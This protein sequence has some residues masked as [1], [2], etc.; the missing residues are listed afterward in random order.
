MGG[1]DHEGNATCEKRETADAGVAQS[2]RC[3]WFRI[4]VV[5]LWMVPAL[6][7]CI[8]WQLAGT[9]RIAIGNGNDSELVQGF[10]PPEQNETTHYRWSKPEA[11]ITLPAHHLPGVL[12]L[13]GAVAPDGTRVTL[14]LGEK[15]RVEIPS[16]GNLALRRYLLLWPAET[17]AQGEVQLGMSAR[18][19]EQTAE[20]RPIGMLLTEVQI[21]AVAGALR[22]PPG[23]PLL[24]LGLFAPL[25]GLCLRLG[26]CCWHF[27][28]G[29]SAAA[30]SLLAGVWV[31]QPLLVRPFL[32]DGAALLAAG[33]LWRWWL[34]MQAV[35]LAALPLTLFLLRHLP[36]RGY[37]FGKTMGLLLVGYGSWLLAMLRLVPFG[38]TSGLLLLLLLAGAGLWSLRHERWST[39]AQG[40]RRRWRALLACEL[41]FTAAL[42][43]GVWLRWHG[44]MGPAIAGTE[45]PMELVLLSGVLRSPTF[46]PADP[47]FAGYSFNYYYMGY[48]LIALLQLLS[49]VNLG[50]AFNLGMATIFALTALSVAGLVVAMIEVTL[51]SEGTRSRQPF[52]PRQPSQPSRLSI[53]GAALLGLLLVLGAGNQMGT[54]QVLVGSPAV[55]TLDGGQIIAAVGQRL[56]GA[57][58]IRLDPPATALA[59]PGAATVITPA[60]TFTFDWWMP[61]RAVWDAVPLDDGTIGTIEKIERR[62]LITEFPFFSFYL[63]DLHPHVLALPVATLALGVTLALLVRPAAPDFLRGTGWLELGLTGVVPGMLYTINAWYAPTFL[64]V[65]AGGLVLLYR[66]LAGTGSIGSIG[67]IDWWGCLRN[68]G[69]VL[70]AMLLLIAPFLLTFQPPGGEQP[71][72]APWSAIPIVRGLAQTLAPAA[73]HTQLHGFLIVFGLF[74]LV[75]LAYG[76]TVTKQHCWRWG[77]P[78][79]VLLIGLP[80]DFPLLALLPTAGLLAWQAWA[81][82]EH[83]ARAL[84]LWGSAVGALVVFGVDIIYIR[85]YLEGEISRLNTLFKFY[86]Q[87]WLIWGVLAAYAAWALWR[88]RRGWGR[89]LAWAVP[90][91]ILLLG[92]LVYPIGA[93]AWGEPWGEPG[94]V[95]DGLAYLEE[96]APDEVAA[97]RWLQTHAAPAEIVLTAFCNCDYDEIGRVSGVTGQPT[98]LGW[99]FAHQ[100]LWRSG[101]PAHMA[102]IQARERD[103][104]RIYTTTDLDEARRLLEQYRVRYVYVG[105]TERR[106][107]AGPGLAKFEQFLEPVFVQGAVRLYAQPV[108]AADQETNR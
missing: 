69:S 26:G 7:V 57:E 52:Q 56:R 45:K 62:P 37:P 102:E 16:A 66:R 81:A 77:I 93:L 99:S 14:H 98:L 92:A 22:M 38:I 61:S 30:G 49:G 1:L 50:V 33:E 2:V 11:Q 75:L 84:L 29:S 91:G 27:S 58:V 106:L 34:A 87:V 39:F 90:A 59:Q 103:I 28:L 5:L 24:L 97:M 8:G 35:G 82:A 54:L 89:T 101:L 23:M 15:A 88:V 42:C 85:D 25:L 4:A 70:L 78:L 21:H 46:P 108:T 86:Y 64:L 20:V 71:V 32:H 36:L 107:Y 104:P 94:R 9:T 51:R 79:L 67:S 40:L 60:Q 55:Q 13:R 95:L 80:F 3:R 76:I 63:G 83:P 41:L 72:P 96:Q 31:W 18:L 6:L 68:L 17:D 53:T 48:V 47:W 43:A 19:P 73:N 44:G 105:P 100:A 65:Y 12:E 74:F 10:Y